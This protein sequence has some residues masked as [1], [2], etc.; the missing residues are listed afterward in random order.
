MRYQSAPCCSDL[1]LIALKGGFLWAVDLP[2]CKAYLIARFDACT[3][4]W[5]ASDG[6]QHDQL[7]IG[8]ICSYQQPH[9]LHLAF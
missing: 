6:R 8:W 3:V 2:A 1:H 5:A 9:S 4:G 7:A